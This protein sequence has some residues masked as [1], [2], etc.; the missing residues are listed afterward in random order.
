M[1]SQSRAKGYLPATA[2]TRKDRIVIDDQGFHFKTRED[3]LI[4]PFPSE[5][6]VQAGLDRFVKSKQKSRSQES[7]EGKKSKRA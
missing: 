1:Y 3:G 5:I 7:K 6:L 4:G 2:F